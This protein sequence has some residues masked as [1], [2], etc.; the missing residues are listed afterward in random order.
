MLI[1]KNN[2]HFF[3]VKCATKCYKMHNALGHGST[4]D[5]LF[6]QRGRSLLF[7]ELQSTPRLENKW[8]F[9]LRLAPSMLSCKPPHNWRGTEEMYVPCYPVRCS[10]AVWFWNPK[11]A[12]VVPDCG[13]SSS[14]MLVSVHQKH[15]TFLCSWPAE[16]SWHPHRPAELCDGLACF[17]RPA[18]GSVNPSCVSQIPSVFVRQQRG[19]LLM[20]FHV[21][22][23]VLPGVGAE[24]K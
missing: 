18:Q 9:V 24:G 5:L 1:F 23:G 4:F 20:T 15:G 11:S 7:S 12:K 6:K 13:T 14:F 3:L 17:P 2:L 21:F 22:T 10:F 19:H 8:G 16:I